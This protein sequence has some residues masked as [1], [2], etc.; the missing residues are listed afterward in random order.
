[1]LGDPLIELVTMYSEISLAVSF[2][3]VFLMDRHSKKV[4]KDLGNTTV[5]ITNHPHHIDP[6]PWVGGLP[7]ERKKF[8]IVAREAFEVQIIKDVSV[9]NETP[10][11]Q[12]PEELYESLRP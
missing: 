9:E 1:M 11:T 3:D 12:H 6:L 2:P 4:S 5:V 10:E 7:D 8:P